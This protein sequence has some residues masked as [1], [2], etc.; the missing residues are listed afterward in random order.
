LPLITAAD[1]ATVVGTRMDGDGVTVAPCFDGGTGALVLR[2]PNIIPPRFGPDSFTRH[3][4]LAQEAGVPGLRCQV[5][6]LAWDLDRPD[7]LGLIE[8]RAGRQDE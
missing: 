4:T 8:A 3:E 2:P 1:V 6:G 5:P 7:D